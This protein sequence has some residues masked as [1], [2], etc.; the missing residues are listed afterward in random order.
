MVQPHDNPLHIEAEHCVVGNHYERWPLIRSLL[1]V[2]PHDNPLHIEAVHCVVGNHRPLL[3][4]IENNPIFYS[5]QQ[6]NFYNFG[7]SKRKSY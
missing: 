6:L 4:G 5:D 7:A 3:L 1:M 2:Q